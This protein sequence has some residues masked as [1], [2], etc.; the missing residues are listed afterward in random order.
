MVLSVA[1]QARAMDGDQR[2]PLELQ[3]DRWCRRSFISLCVDAP[4]AKGETP[5]GL[6]EENLSSCGRHRSGGD[7]QARITHDLGDAAKGE[8]A[9]ASPCDLALYCSKC[10]CSRAARVQHAWAWTRGS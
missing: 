1:P 7:T 2:R 4:T 3:R 8:W 10:V 5:G 9:L 6:E